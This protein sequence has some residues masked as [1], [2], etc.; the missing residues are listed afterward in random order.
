MESEDFVLHTIPSRRRAVHLFLASALF[1]TACSDSGNVIGPENSPEVANLT[2]S[3][4]WQVTN[5]DQVTQT[6]TYTWV[7]TGTSANV[8]Q[9]S[10]LTGG[11]A[12][13]RLSDSEGTVVFEGDLSEGGSFQSSTGV[14]GDWSVRVVLTRASGSFNFR[15]QKP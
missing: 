1:F 12:T 15:L 7:N 13:V 3:F 5:L 8:D 4:Q 6:L 10:S 11:T 14:A 2:D 9:S